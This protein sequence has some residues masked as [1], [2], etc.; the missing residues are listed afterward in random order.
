MN[1]ASPPPP[2]LP[3]VRVRLWLA[4][5]LL[6]VALG[7]LAVWFWAHAHPARFGSYHDDGIYVVTAKALATGQGYRIISL[8]DAPAQT[9]YPPFYP[10][11]LSLVWRARPD[12]PENLRPMMGLS[13]LAAVLFL[14]FSYAYLVGRGHAGRGLAL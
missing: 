11:L 5:G 13:A 9:K 8:P 4:A 6:S 7:S 1:C 14:G 10:W 3:A 2:P 12:F